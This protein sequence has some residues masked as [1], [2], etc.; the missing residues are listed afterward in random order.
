MPPSP[1]LWSSY[2]GRNPTLKR[3]ELEVTLPVIDAARDRE[4]WLPVG[5]AGETRKATP[6]F[7][8]STFHWQ[9]RLAITQEKILSTVCVPLSLLVG[10][11][12]AVPLLTLSL[13]VAR[14]YALRVALYSSPVQNRVSEIKCVLSSSLTD[15]GLSL[16]SLPPPPPQP[17]ARSL[18]FGP[19]SRPQ[20]RSADLSTAAA[21]HHHVRLLAFEAPAKLADPCFDSTGSTPCSTSSSSFCTARSTLATTRAPTCR[22]TTRRFGGATRRRLGS[23]P[24]SRCARP[25]ARPSFPPSSGPC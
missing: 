1:R 22:S 7:L 4:P 19:A 3:A 15:C 13:S 24:C 6:S 2:V 16:T 21:A 12:R 17:R 18:G 25:L 23:S 20:D 5:A 14:S 11:V 9:C 8:S 10:A